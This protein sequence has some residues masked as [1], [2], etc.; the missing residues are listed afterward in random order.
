MRIDRVYAPVETLGP[1]K[2]IVVWACGCSKRCPGCANP[3]LWPAEEGMELGQD[4]LA[5]MLLEMAKRSGITRLTFTG[6]DPL[7]QGEA[8][9]GLL[10]KIRHGFADILIYTGYTL[11]EAEQVLGVDG[12]AEF[13][14]LADAVIDGPY[15]EGLNDGECALRGS[16]N[17]ALTVFNDGLRKEYERA[18]AEPRRVQN[19]VFDGRAISIGI[20]GGKARHTG[21]VKGA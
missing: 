20:H 12:F 14:Q 2:R 11:K 3:E 17:Q 13:A 19:A 15:V 4:E 18:L 1:G 5:A 9:M 6:G 21:K 10:R 16:T 7:E 8:L